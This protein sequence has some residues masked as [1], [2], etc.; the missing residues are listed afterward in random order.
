[1][2][3]ASMQCSSGSLC[4]HT[5]CRRRCFLLHAQGDPADLANARQNKKKRADRLC[6]LPSTL[7]R[8]RDG[9]ES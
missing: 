2:L 6:F 9:V 5:S 4:L 3:R 8:L 7:P 1:M